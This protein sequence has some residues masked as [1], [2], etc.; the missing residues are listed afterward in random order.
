M[1]DMNTIE[2][3]RYHYTLS[4]VLHYY[5]RHEILYL[6]LGGLVSDFDVLQH[7]TEDEYYDVMSSLRAQRKPKF[8]E[9]L[10]YGP[11]TEQV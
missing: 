4:G 5:I 1:E 6:E 11:Y 10:R 8:M 9:M 3:R 7:A 2:E